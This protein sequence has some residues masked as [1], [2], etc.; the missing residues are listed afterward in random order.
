V[1]HLVIPPIS[2]K[3]FLVQC[4]FKFFI[5]VIQIYSQPIQTPIPA[6]VAQFLKIL[7]FWRFCLMLLFIKTGVT[8]NNHNTIQENGIRYRH[9]MRFWIIPIV[10]L[11]LVSACDNQLVTPPSNPTI[12]TPLTPVP[13]IA[14]KTT[15]RV[16]SD[17]TRIQ[18]CLN[19]V[20]PGDT[21][22]ISAGTYNEALVLTRNGT[23][24]APIFLKA[25]GIVTINSGNERTLVTLGNVHDWVIDGFRF[26]STHV[27][28]SHPSNIGTV[29]FGYNYWGDGDQGESGNDR[30][31]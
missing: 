20:R 31:I 8:I 2:T 12:S 30:F 29:N 6:L 5:Q 28:T 9:M 10:G 15:Y 16:P 7:S 24:N 21:C 4:L 23:S 3:P 22:L 18:D 17:F 11:F 27:D 1:L 25:D 13:S 26:L 14:I 19:V